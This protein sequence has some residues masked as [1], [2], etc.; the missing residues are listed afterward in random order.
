MCLPA[1]DSMW[2]IYAMEAIGFD[3]PEVQAQIAA[4]FE[5]MRIALA[6]LAEACRQALQAMRD[7]VQ[8]LIRA[9]VQFYRDMCRLRL[10]PRQSRDTI[11]KRKLRRHVVLMVS[12]N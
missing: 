8:P 12:R 3:S 9:I 4:V 7:A 10:I 11:A 5:Q 1:I 2:Y 6:Q